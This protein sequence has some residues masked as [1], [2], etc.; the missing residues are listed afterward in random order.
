M[1][2]SKQDDE[3]TPH[4]EIE[5]FYEDVAQVEP[6][7]YNNQGITLVI[8]KGSTTS[9]DN[10]KPHNASELGGSVM[11]V[12]TVVDEE[13]DFDYSQSHLEDFLR[14]HHGS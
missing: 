7:K 14:T 5:D 4:E 2:D 12:T 6:P 10:K 1:D 9:A 11:P 13:I 3:N 8:Q